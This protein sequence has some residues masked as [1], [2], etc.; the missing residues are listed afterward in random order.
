MYQ[1]FGLEM[2]GK[3]GMTSCRGYEPLRDTTSFLC[4]KVE[5]LAV[6]QLV[7]HGQSWLLE[8][9]CRLTCVCNSAFGALKVELR[10]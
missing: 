1:S 9:S 2:T 10:P 4:Y 7:L 6:T 8:L 3:V 5:Y